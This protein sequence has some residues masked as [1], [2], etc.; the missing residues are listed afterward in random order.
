VLIDGVIPTLS[1]GSTMMRR[2]AL[3]DAGGRNR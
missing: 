2:V 1:E 3:A